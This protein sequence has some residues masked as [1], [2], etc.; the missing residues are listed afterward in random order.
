MGT[1]PKEIDPIDITYLHELNIVEINNLM[2]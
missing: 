2:V 1:Y